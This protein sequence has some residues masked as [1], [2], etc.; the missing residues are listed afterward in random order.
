M[1]NNQRAPI[2]P[3]RTHDTNDSGRPLPGWVK[4][5]A[6]SGTDL[7]PLLVEFSL[8]LKQGA[9]TRAEIYQA[10]ERLLEWRTRR[11]KRVSGLRPPS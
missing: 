4:N 1:V 7:R 3:L 10:G 9:H 2:K 8:L 11:Q 6:G 5:L